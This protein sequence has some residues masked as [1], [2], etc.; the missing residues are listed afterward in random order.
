M[1]DRDLALDLLDDAVRKLDAAQETLGTIKQEDGE[2]VDL[3]PKRKAVLTG[4]DDLRADLVRL[5]EA[6]TA[7][8]PEEPESGEPDSPEPPDDVEDSDHPAEPEAPVEEEPPADLFSLDDQHAVSKLMQDSEVHLAVRR[9]RNFWEIRHRNTADGRPSEP[10][11]AETIAG[12]YALYERQ[13]FRKG[14]LQQ[15]EPRALNAEEQQALADFRALR[16]D[17]PRS[18]RWELTKTEV[19]YIDRSG[20]HAG[21]SKDDVEFPPGEL[22]GPIEHLKTVLG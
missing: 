22:I 14:A 16:V 8:A 9:A 3:R 5:R 11:R 15:L 7:A 18:V 21:G 6:V 19:D 10:L 13:A 1:F 2:V 17:N 4:L 12:A 20:E